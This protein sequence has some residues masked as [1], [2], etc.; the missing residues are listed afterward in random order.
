M[1]NVLINA[2]A[3]S[4]NWGSEPGLGWNWV[5]N[6]AKYCNV[7]VITE[8][9]WKQEIEAAVEK[10]P[11]KTISIFITTHSLTELEKMC[12]N[13]ED[14]RFYKYYR[15]WQEKT[16]TIAKEI[17]ANNQIDVI[18]QLNMIGFREPGSLWKINGIPFI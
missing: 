10:L 11:Q 6:L 7:Y 9:E 2:Y 18:H 15:Q 16:L 12:W 4:P 3:V 17:I 5:T 1:I 14:W 13:Q 8:G